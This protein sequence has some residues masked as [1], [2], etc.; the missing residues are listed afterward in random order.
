[1]DYVIQP[2]VALTTEGL[3]W[4][5]ITKLPNPERVEAMRAKRRCNPFR[6]ENILWNVNLG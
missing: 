1:M 3:R 4:V 2:S 6:V 5:D